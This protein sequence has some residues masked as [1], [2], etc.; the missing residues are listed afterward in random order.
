MPEGEQKNSYAW[1]VAVASIFIV[2][3][4]VGFARFGYTLILPRML[5]ALNL[6][7]TQ[8]GAVA[9]ANMLGY[10]IFSLIC[11][12]LATRYGPRVVIVVAI[13]VTAIAL[14]GT[15]FSTSFLSASVWR[16]IAGAGGGGANVPIMGLISGWFVAKRR[17]LASGMAVSGSSFALLLTGILLPPV[18]SRQGADGWRSGWFLLGAITLVITVAALLAVKNSPQQALSE[19]KKPQSIASYAKSKKIW[20]LSG[21][22]M[23]FG[24]SYVIFAT[25]FA[26]Y[27]VSEGGL[28]EKTVGSMWSAIG[29][30]SVVSG[31]L[32]GVASDRYGRR[33]AL[34]G[35]FFVQALAYGIFAFWHTMPG[36]LVGALLFGLTAWSIPAVMGATVGDFYGPRAAPAVFGF[37]TLVFGVGQAFGPVVAGRIADATGSYSIAF[38][39]AALVALAGAPLSFLVKGSKKAL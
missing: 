36:Y 28:S 5:T 25:F 6:S 30:V 26:R 34:S 16:F 3:G 24:F 32:W 2:M 15:G 39:M 13:G 18:M 12:L 22:Y 14:I 31:F 27:L 17:G 21:L 33:A 11:G 29:G 23:L 4:A 8:A 38:A 35:I 7:D 20:I 10:L 9:T 1:V 19:T 37:V